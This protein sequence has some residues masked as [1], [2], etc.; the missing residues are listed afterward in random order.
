M[1][2]LVPGKIAVDDVM[3]YER[4]R[5]YNLPEWNS[6]RWSQRDGQKSIVQRRR[7]Q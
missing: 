5:K 1:M 2:I 4:W 7:I 6:L 3:L